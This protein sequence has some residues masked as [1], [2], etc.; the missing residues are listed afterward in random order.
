M[1]QRRKQ[2]AERKLESEDWEFGDEWKNT[3]S[4]VNLTGWKE[5][6]TFTQEFSRL[7]DKGIPA[8]KRETMNINEVQ[9][10]LSENE[11][12]SHIVP[13]TQSLTPADSIFVEEKNFYKAK[14]VLERANIQI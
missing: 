10:L 5:L 13:H 1:G 3:L 9:T 12:P 7:Y 4:E 8:L 14:E 2:L 6:I 11:I